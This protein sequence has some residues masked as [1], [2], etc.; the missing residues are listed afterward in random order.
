MKFDVEVKPSPEQLA[1]AFWHMGDDE[2]ARFFNHLSEI[3]EWKFPFQLQS[4]T[5]HSG[6]TLAGR[7]VMQEIGEYSHWGISC[8]VASDVLR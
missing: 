2:Q 7:R 4:I 6:L 5:E 3:A 8:N 1:E